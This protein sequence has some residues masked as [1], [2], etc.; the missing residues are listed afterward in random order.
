MRTIELEIETHKCLEA[1][2]TALSES[3]TQTTTLKEKLATNEVRHAAEIGFEQGQVKSGTD[4]VVN[5]LLY[6]NYCCY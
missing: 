1:M 2:N 3:E 4:Y 5:S 6:C